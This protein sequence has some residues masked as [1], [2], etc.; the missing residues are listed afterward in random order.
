MLVVEDDYWIATD[1]ASIIA[2]AGAEVV[3]PVGCVQ[4]AFAVLKPSPDLASLDVQLGAETS[5]PIADEPHWRGTPF[6]FATSAANL[7]P[8]AHRGNA[9]FEEHQGSFSMPENG[10]VAVNAPNVPRRWSW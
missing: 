1:L 10:A 4:D 9:R 2:D 8:A 6:I 5:F 3:G 7:I